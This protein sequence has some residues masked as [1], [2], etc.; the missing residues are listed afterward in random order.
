MR[1]PFS[2]WFEEEECEDPEVTANMKNGKWS[3]LFPC[4]ILAGMLLGA[5]GC[6]RNAATRAAQRIPPQAIAPV[7]QEAF[8]KKI[9]DL[10]IPLY[11]GALF[12]EVRRQSSGSPLLAAVYEVATGSD[13]RYGQIRKFYDEGIRQALVAKGW[14]ETPSAQNVIAYRKGFEVLYA[15]FSW[16]VV[17]PNAKKLQIVIEYGS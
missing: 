1:P 11:Q 5:V 6:T 4:L 7:D 16:L 14:T 9:A 17:P 10:G 3:L 15:E 13:R 2:L 8:L 12:Q